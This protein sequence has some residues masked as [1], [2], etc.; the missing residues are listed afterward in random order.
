MSKTSDLENFRSSTKI[1][2]TQYR[3][4][5]IYFMGPGAPDP[6]SWGAAI[7]PNPLNG[8]LGHEKSVKF[9]T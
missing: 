8:G 1:P 4:G 5:A 7:P 6:V 9:A 2:L 3:L